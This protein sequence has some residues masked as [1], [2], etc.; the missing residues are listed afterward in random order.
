MS[1]HTMN[2]RQPKRVHGGVL[3][4]GSVYAI[5]RICIS[6]G[7]ITIELIVAVLA[8]IAVMW[9]WRYYRWKKHVEK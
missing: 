8:Y 2:G 1:D 6:G 9:V 5:P 7:W 4:I 3:R